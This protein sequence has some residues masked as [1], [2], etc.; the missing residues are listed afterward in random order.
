MVAQE[1]LILVEVR[2]GIECKNLVLVGTQIAELVVGILV[3]E[4]KEREV[5]NKYFGLVGYKD[6]YYPRSCRS[7]SE[8]HTKCHYRFD[9]TGPVVKVFGCNLVFE[10]AEIVDTTDAGYLEVVVDSAVSFA[11]MEVLVES[12]LQFVAFFEAAPSGSCMLGMVFAVQT[13]MMTMMLVVYHL[14]AVV[15]ESLSVLMFAGVVVS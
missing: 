10:V 15:Y 4:R 11:V 1:E 14:S 5:E 7:S 8:K 12:V 2:V 3:V 13:E 9:C 6:H